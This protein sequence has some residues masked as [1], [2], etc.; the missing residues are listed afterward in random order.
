MNREKNYQKAL[1]LLEKKFIKEADVLSA[2][3]L[4]LEI[5]NYK[6]S[7]QLLQKCDEQIIVFEKQKNYND[8]CQ[9]ILLAN[10]ECEK[11][12]ET[13]NP[14][15]IRHAES[16]LRSAIED[17]KKI[18]DYREADEKIAECDVLIQQYHDK[19]S[20]ISSTS[21][22]NHLKRKK[23]KRN[24]IKTAIVSILI[25]LMSYVVVFFIPAFLVSPDKYIPGLENMYLFPKYVVA[26][27]FFYGGNYQV[28]RTLFNDVGEFGDSMEKLK[29]IETDATYHLA[30]KRYEEKNY[31]EA[32]KLFQSVTYKDS[33]EKEEEVAQYIYE[34]AIACMDRK[35]YER[36]LE[37]F[38]KVKY[39]RDTDG[40]VQQI[41]KL[42]REP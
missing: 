39:Y 7:R 35:E 17:L 15:Y 26:N 3:E 2:K 10:T 38:D 1:S 36:A 14:G 28:A 23:V 16:T 8:A 30:I 42:M 19:I 5:D 34:E 4:L 18:R 37:L 32:L 25:V 41:Q 27:A 12:V 22:L 29:V 24:K 33:L 31:T 9:K 21:V 13:Q 40:Y 6:N 11:G 20:E